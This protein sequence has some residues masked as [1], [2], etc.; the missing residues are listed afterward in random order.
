MKNTAGP[1]RSLFHLCWPNYQ[2]SVILPLEAVLITGVLSSLQ[3]QN[4]VDYY[5]RLLPRG[6]FILLSLASL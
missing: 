1:D 6:F 2:N 5:K 4:K 3:L